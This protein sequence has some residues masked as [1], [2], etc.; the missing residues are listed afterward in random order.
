MPRLSALLLT[1]LLAAAVSASAVEIPLTAPQYGPASNGQLR[2]VT[3][4]DGDSYFVLWT[5]DRTRARETWGTR[6]ARNG[7]LL[8]PTGI[9]LFDREMTQPSL[10]WTGTSYLAAWATDG[11]LWMLRVDRDGVVVDPAHVVL[12]GATPTSIT[13]SATQIAIGFRRGHELR[14]LFVTRDGLPIVDVL[15]GAPEEDTIGPQLAWNGLHFVAIWTAFPRIEG[16]RFGQAG[17]IDREPRVIPSDGALFQPR[18]ASNGT[19]FVIVASTDFYGG[20]HLAHHVSTDLTSAGPPVALPADIYSEASIVWTGQQYIVVASQGARTTGVRLDAEARLLD[21]GAITIE[22][23]PSTGATAQPS[24]ATNGSDLFIAW[25][26]RVVPDAEGS[27]DVYGSLT[28]PSNLASRSRALLS[29]TARRETRP[30]VANGGT[31]LLAI[32]NEPT[33]VWAK[34]IGLQGATIDAVPIRI[35]EKEGPTAVTFNGTDYLVAWTDSREIRTFRIRRD[36]VLRADEGARFQATDG[37]TLALASNATTNVLAYGGNAARV[38]RLAGD[39]SLIGTPIVL[40]ATTTGAVD[41][42]ANDSGE[43]LVAWGEMEFLPPTFETAQPRRVMATRLNSSLI[44]LHPGG[45]RI[46]DTSAFEGEPS[47]AWNGREWLIAWTEAKSILYG[48]HLASNGTFTDDATFIAASAMLPDVAWDGARYVVAWQ[49][50][51]GGF[52]T[53]FRAAWFSRLGTPALYATEFGEAEFWPPMPITVIATTPGDV[54]ISY[55]RLA[56]E[57]QYGSVARA[58]VNIGRPPAQ[59]RRAAQ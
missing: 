5:D 11:D 3:A 28:S 2:S 4:S 1:I 16:V 6:V 41:V 54:A 53:L 47:I 50:V 44:N 31:N 20:T 38:V 14:A 15:L 32:W 33:G 34:R 30:I 59:R 51:A 26:G 23:A 35:V 18:I 37:F 10:I 25:N 24:V 46:A 52:P 17:A 40:A 48:R 57:P 8:D 19:D 22:D 55:A 12:R 29:V 39:G 42:A 49:G 21:A 58:F 36:G 43:F 56:R 9:A 7:Q 13:R 27:I 45:I